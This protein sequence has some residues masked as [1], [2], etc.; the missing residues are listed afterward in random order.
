MKKFLLFLSLLF[1]SIIGYAQSN[2]DEEILVFFNSGVSQVEKSFNG[3]K[4]KT[5]KITKDK[6]MKSLSEIGITNTLMEIAIPMFNKA[7]TLKVLENGQR[8]KQL[9]MTKTI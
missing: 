8:I 6:L 5:A 7:D 3:K 1:L 2:P 4:V 9:D